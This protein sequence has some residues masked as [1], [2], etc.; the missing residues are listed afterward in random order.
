MISNSNVKMVSAL[1]FIALGALGAL[2][3]GCAHQKQNLAKPDMGL[4]Q[5]KTVAQTHHFNPAVN[6]VQLTPTTTTKGSRVA[7]TT[8]ISRSPA[9]GT[10]VLVPVYRFFSPNGGGGGVR[11]E[12]FFTLSNTEVKTNQGWSAEGIGF[13]VLA[14]ADTGTAGLYRC[15]EPNNG[16]H[17][18]SRDTNCEGYRNEGIYG[19]VYT[20]QGPGMVPLLR[21][22]NNDGDRG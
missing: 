9:S 21:F 7:K 4:D 10:P 3:A 16:F 19:Y 11:G 17:F 12:H 5:P 2:G 6:P 22:Y 14:T 20:A 13:Y 1:A 15:Y 18:V 8:K